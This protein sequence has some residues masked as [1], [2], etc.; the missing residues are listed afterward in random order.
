MAKTRE[1]EKEQ[2]EEQEKDEEEEE[3]QSTQGFLLCNYATFKK[4]LS[5]INALSAEWRRFKICPSQLFLYKL[6]QFL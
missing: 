5:Q 3:T 4:Q 2:E 6:D 1:D